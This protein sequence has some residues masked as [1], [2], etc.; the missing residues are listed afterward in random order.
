MRFKAHDEWRRARRVLMGRGM[1]SLRRSRSAVEELDAIRPLTVAESLRDEYAATLPAGYDLVL[2]FGPSRFCLIAKGPGGFQE[3]EC[4]DVAPEDA[5]GLSLFRRLAATAKFHHR[6]R[7][8]LRV[9]SSK[10]RK[11]TH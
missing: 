3:R 5:L 7:T 1:T 11:V 10:S 4:V 9:K 6:V 2:E 8:G